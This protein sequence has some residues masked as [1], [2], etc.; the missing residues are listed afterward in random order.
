MEV[1]KRT[2]PE[3]PPA[4]S[5]FR[6]HAGRYPHPTIT[7][8][9]ASLITFGAL[10]SP[11]SWHGS[12]SCRDPIPPIADGQSCLHVVGREGR[13]ASFACS[14]GAFGAPEHQEGS[15]LDQTL[16]FELFLVLNYTRVSPGKEFS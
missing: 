5:L 1:E 13:D 6:L 4:P 15:K 14:R 10:L 7:Q 16:C 2:L 3:H 11:F 9:S 12:W 8:G